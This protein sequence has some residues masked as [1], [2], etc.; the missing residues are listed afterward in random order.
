MADEEQPMMD[1]EMKEPEMMDM[2]EEPPKDASMMGMS[3]KSI[4][5]VE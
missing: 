4:D 3:E 1:E 5:E 2:M